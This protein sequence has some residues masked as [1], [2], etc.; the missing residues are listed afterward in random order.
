V[1]LNHDTRLYG[2]HLGERREFGAPRAEVTRHPDMPDVTGLRNLS[3]R[4]WSVRTGAGSSFVVEPGRSVT[5]AA[6]T[7]I[8]FG[9]ATGVIEV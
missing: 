5:L 6:G 3:G 1:L 7:Q 2:H 4:R 8:D 9:G